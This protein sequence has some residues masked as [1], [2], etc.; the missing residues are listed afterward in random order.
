MKPKLTEGKSIPPS[1]P[2]KIVAAKVSLSTIANI[3]AILVLTFTGLWVY[4]EYTIRRI[5]IVT[6]HL[7]TQPVSEIL[8]NLDFTNF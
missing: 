4:R 6:D 5:T 8:T 7:D 2:N 3:F 1:E